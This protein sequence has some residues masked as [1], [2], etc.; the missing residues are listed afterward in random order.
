MDKNE[1]IIDIAPQI[2]GRVIS[3]NLIEA[4]GTI[5]F[6]INSSQLIKKIGYLFKVASPDYH[7][8]VGFT[9]TSFY[10]T[11]NDQRLEMPIEP[12][13]EAGDI[14]C[15]AIWQQTELSLLILD[16]SYG[17][18]ISSGADNTDEMKKR[19]KILRTPSTIPPKSLIDNI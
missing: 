9:E 1:V 15:Y 14:N 8:E 12:Y 19:K 16:K 5:T 7:L 11:R 3:R 18:A 6:W 4:N 17:E 10:I 2:R 13:R